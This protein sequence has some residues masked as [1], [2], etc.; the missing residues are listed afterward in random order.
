MGANFE[1]K[2]F[3]IFEWRRFKQSSVGAKMRSA[4]SPLLA[5]VWIMIMKQKLNIALPLFDL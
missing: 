1:E 2:W 5:P 4:S 3:P